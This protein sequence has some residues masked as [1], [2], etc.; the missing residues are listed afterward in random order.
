MQ[1]HLS[2]EY[3]CIRIPNK[4]FYIGSC[5]NT[6]FV[7][8]K[9]GFPSPKKDQLTI[10]P[11]LSGFWQPPEVFYYNKGQVIQNLWPFYPLLGGHVITSE[12]DHLF[13]IQ[14]KGHQQNCQGGNCSFSLFGFPRHIVLAATSLQRM[15]DPVDKP[16]VTSS[17]W[18]GAT[19]RL[20]AEPRLVLALPAALVRGTSKRMSSNHFGL[21]RPY[22]PLLKVFFWW[23]SFDWGSW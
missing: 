1:K 7:K 20:G 17:A 8:V 14:K 4:Q 9:N 5:Q 6:G 15:Q 10:H 21:R 3:K 19:A 22:L 16:P 12:R 2:N 11:L 13:T 23:G 18:L